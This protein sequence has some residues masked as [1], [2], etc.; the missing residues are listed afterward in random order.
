[1]RVEESLRELPRL[2]DRLRGC[3]MVSPER[4]AITGNRRLWRVCR[5]NVALVGDASGT[6]DAI[7]G[8]GLGLAFR[9]AAVLAEC[10]RSDDLARYQREHRRLARRPLLMARMMLNLDQRPW[11]QERT[12]QTF[13]K[14][15]EVFRRLLEFHIGSL[16]A[17]HL[18]TEG[19]TLGWGLLTS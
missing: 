15:P 4:G 11:L 1:L 12:L 10:L 19:L 3:E 8:E 14:H 9:Q 16:P 2:G 7:T 17:T 13:Q 5:G 18:I 6:V